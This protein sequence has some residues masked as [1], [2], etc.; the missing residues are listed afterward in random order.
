[1]QIPIDWPGLA[2]LI[3]SS[4]FYQLSA[5]LIVSGVLGFIALQLRQPLIVA[6]I[7]VGLLVGPGLLGVIGEESSQIDTLAALGIALLLFLVGLKLDLSLIKALGPVALITG[8]TQVALT[9]ALG[10]GIAYWLG[11]TPMQAF[12]IGIALAFSSTIIVV[13]LLSDSGAIESL[14]GKIAL[15]ILIVQDIIVILSMVVVT[16]LGTGGPEVQIG[17]EVFALVFA[18]VFALLIA[19]A[20][21]VRYVAD[22]LTKSLAKSSELIVIFALGLAAVMAALCHALDLSKELGGLLAGVALASTP[23][24]DMI[25]A[26]LAPL[27]DFLL[28]FFFLGLGAQLDLG[29]IGDQIIPA[30]ILSGFVL[31]GKP[32]IIMSIMGLLGYRRRTGYMSGTTLA[33]ISEFS[34]IFTGLAVAAGQLPDNA[35]GL[36]TLVGMITITVSVY[37]MLFQD[38]LFSLIEKALGI[39]ERKMPKYDEELSDS[40]KRGTYDVLVFGMGR[41]GLAMSSAFKKNGAKVL[42]VDFDP[43]AIRAAQDYKFP[44]IYGDASDPEFVKALPLKGVNTVVL[45]FPHHIT[46]PFMPDIRMS[47]ARTLREAGYAGHI[48][49]TSHFRA[50][51]KELKQNGADIVLCPFEDAASHGADHIL[52]ILENDRIENKA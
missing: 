19:T 48:A 12:W 20:L 43:E 27:R 49:V 23:I 29:Q 11:F 2:L 24:R 38:Q 40:H 44:A 45:A 9:T 37:L 4:L 28:L 25:A 47:F 7:G 50:A 42:G 33:Q 10:F 32:V 46:G 15:G 21:F 22:P 51:E 6:F 17:W 14:Y 18:K 3:Q 34:M 52:E 26:K 8:L 30:L 16:A 31:I 39:F 1:M 36:M 13:K 5:L 35:A 41:F